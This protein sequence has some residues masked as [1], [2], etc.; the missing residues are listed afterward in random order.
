[1]T[2]TAFRIT[3]KQFASSIWSGFGAREFGGRWDSKGVAVVYTAENRSLAAM[4]QLVHLVKPRILKGYVIAN[5]SFDAH[6]VTRLS[7]GSLP[8]GWKN[9]IAL[10]ALKRYGD[11][12]IDAARHVILAVPSVVIP[13]EWNYLLNPA[14]PEFRAL[15]K[16]APKRFGYDFRLT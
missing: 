11:N 4:E 15:K 3:R 12:W 16:S 6:Q 10:P 1:M 9:P 5:I 7:P 14:H 13:G 8:A 2:I